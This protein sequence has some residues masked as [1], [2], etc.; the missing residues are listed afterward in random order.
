[1]DAD[2]KRRDGDFYGFVIS[3]ENKSGN[4]KGYLIS[5][6]PRQFGYLVHRVERIAVAFRKTEI[7]RNNY[8]VIEYIDFQR[9][10][11]R[12]ETPITTK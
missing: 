8:M 12:Q 2:V 4:Q 6:E 10:T 3:S 9:Q 5:S 11:Q 7:T 1:M